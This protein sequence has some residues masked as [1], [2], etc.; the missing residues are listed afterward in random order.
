MMTSRI[1][2]TIQIFD[3]IQTQLHLEKEIFLQIK[4]ITL[5]KMKPLH[6]AVKRT[7]DP[8]LTHTFPAPTDIRQISNLHCLQSALIGSKFYSSSTF[9]YISKFLLIASTGS[10]YE[11]TH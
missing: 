11:Q 5:L 9:L 6:V 2:V 4:P 7:Y 10:S 1:Q 3:K 8:T